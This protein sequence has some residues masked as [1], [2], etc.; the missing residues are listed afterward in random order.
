MSQMSPTLERLIDQIAKLPGLGK[1]SALRIAL[2]ILKQSE[3]DARALA[4]AIMQVKLR[5]HLCPRCGNLTESE[6]CVICAD[7]K[8]DSQMLCIVES[9][10]DI[11]RLEKA[12]GYRG[13]YHVLGGVLSPL[14]GVGPEALRMAELWTRTTHETFR[15]VIL[16]ISPT[17]DGDATS[18]YLLREL[19]EKQIPA[20]RLARGVPIGAELEH[21]D[22]VTLARALAERTRMDN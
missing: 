14:D 7:P 19:K 10:Q 20:T 5:L 4:E 2:H 22:E 15:E 16:A 18:L 6:L 21:V 3:P 11:L 9:P 12:T 17:A 8:R 1:K 13:V